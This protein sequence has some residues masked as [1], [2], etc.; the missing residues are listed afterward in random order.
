MLKDKKI[1]VV[2]PA[3]NAAA[4]LEKTY[5]E[6]PHDIVDEVII[7]D[8]HSSDNTPEIAHALGIKHIIVHDRNWGYGRNQKTC[9]QCALDLGADIIVMIHPD[10]QYTPKLCRS[11]ASLIAEDIFQCVL[12]SRILGPGAL[13]GGMPLYKY[14]ANRLLTA[15][16]NFFLGY[17]LSEYHTGYR[18]FSREILETL[19]LQKNDDGFIFDNQMLVQIIAAGFKIGEITCPTRYMQDSSSINFQKA[20]GYG[21][22][23]IKTTLVYLFHRWKICSSSLFSFSRS[24][25]LG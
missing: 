7:V 10:Y 11:M 19:P 22:G 6:I 25:K 4:T 24:K 23:V 21:L 9:Y 17:K 13:V 15:F 16:Q 8:D 3:Y 20:V 2:M 14:V 18:A 1:V 5:R 12:G